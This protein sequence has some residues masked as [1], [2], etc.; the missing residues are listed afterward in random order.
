MLPAATSLIQLSTEYLQQRREIYR[1]EISV[2]HGE[3]AT[4]KDIKSECRKLLAAFPEATNDYLIVLIERLA[5]N[6][7]T[8]QRV[9][10]AINNVIDSCPYKKPS[11]S[12][13]IS[14]DKKVKLYTYNEI[15]AK[16]FQGCKDA[17]ENYE[18]VNINGQWRYIEK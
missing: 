1:G 7:F 3:K 2:Y 12:E 18:R 16:G 8:A 9:K 4:E 11:I 15:Q 10:D 17:F 6:G 13:I 14:F 5:D